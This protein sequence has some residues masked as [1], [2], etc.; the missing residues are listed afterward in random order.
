M[1]TK[2]HT[3]PLK[4]M[5]GP[6]RPY[7]ATHVANLGTIFRKH[8]THEKPQYTTEDKDLASKD[9]YDLQFLKNL[10][11]TFF[12]PMHIFCILAHI[13]FH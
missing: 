13:L 7:K 8:G 1:A 6:I 12:V 2:D 9:H 11:G 4:I 10:I 5:Q 3:R